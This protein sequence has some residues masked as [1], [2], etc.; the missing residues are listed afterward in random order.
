MG[1]FIADTMACSAYEIGAY[2]LILCHLWRH[3]GE[4]AFDDIPQVAR[5]IPTDDEG[6]GITYHMVNRVVDQAITKWLYTNDGGRTYRQKRVDIELERAKA[7]SETKQQASLLGVAA[8][9]AKRNQSV[10]HMVENSP[11]KWTTQS[12]SQSQEKKI[13]PSASLQAQEI[14]VEF[15]EI[16]RNGKIPPCPFDAIAEAY[17]AELPHLPAIVTLTPHRKRT[18]QARWREVVTADHLDREAG[19]DFFRDFFKRVN[20]SEFLTGKAPPKERGGRSFRADFDWIFNPQNFV[21]IIEGKYHK[22]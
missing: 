3:D 1:D 14:S 21:K 10:N 18:V 12:Q 4:I 22:G 5:I 9:A 11:T 2:T 19:I 8:K 13:S 15:S 7:V 20:S 16:G 17:H 6:D